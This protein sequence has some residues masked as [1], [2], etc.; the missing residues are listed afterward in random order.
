MNTLIDQPTKGDIKEALQYLAKGIDGLDKTYEQ[1]MKRIE[2]QGSRVQELAKHILGW[3]IHAKRPLSTAELRHALGVRPGAE[4]LDE[5]YLPS[6]QVLRS[7]CA[8]LVT[9]DKQS[10][11]VRLVHYT[12]QEYF[13]RTWT[14]WFPNAQMDITSVC[15]TYLLFDVFKTGFCQS[16][17]EFGARLRTNVLYDY[18]A[19]NWGHHAYTVST[20]EDLILNLLESRAKV[21][22]ASQA[23]MVSGNCSG[24]SQRVPTQI[25]GVHVAAYF[26]LGGTITGLLKNRYNPDLQDSY[27]RT[28]LSWAA[29]GG[30]EAV[31]KLLL[32]AGGVDVD[33]KDKYGQT[34]LSW[35]A[36]RG[37][38][39][40]VKLLLETGKVD[41]DSKDKPFGQTPLWWAAGGGHE[42]VVKLLLETGKADV[43]PKDDPG[44]TPLSLAA[45]RGHEA[46]VKLLLE[47]GEVDVDSKDDHGRTPLSWAAEKGHEAV[48]K[49]LVETG[50]VDIDSKGYYDDRTP[51][52]RVAERGHEAMVKLL[53]ETGKV[54]V[55][56]KE[57]KYGRTPL[58]W[59]AGGGHEAMVKLLLE[60]GKVDV[61]LKDD[62]GRTPLSWAAEGGHEA[63]AKLLQQSI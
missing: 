58:L 63:V 33:S 37:H 62:S 56:L 48:V 13:E 2:D 26:G 20:K 32:E 7:V 6:I 18:A 4:K 11:I 15:V 35:A 46:V 14:S 40:V 9:V 8:G 44:Q 17:K 60:T 50:K 41:V 29:E 61:N 38:K 55:N 59:A 34:P 27:G 22:A 49:L 3:I 39:A 19:R 24:Y 53:L 25:T 10:G 28:P 21:S 36:E 43:D 12:T 31:V 1:A 47:T 54:D 45:K 42:A 30:H 51:L 52:S 5:D 16:D 23:M 57:D